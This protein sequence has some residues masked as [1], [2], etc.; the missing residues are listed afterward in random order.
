MRKRAER[1]TLAGMHNLETRL[2]REFGIRYPFVSAGM[3]FVAH[4]RLAAAVSNAGGLG[5]LGASPDP[6]ESLP[7]MIERLRGLTDGPFGVDL[8]CA[9]LPNG[10]ASTE[11]HIDRC[12][13]LGVKLVAFHHEL[14]PP[15][16]V[17]RLTAAGARV[18][19]QASSL[20]LARAAVALGMHGIVAQ[21]VEAGGHCESKVPVLDLV[22]S[23]RQAFPDLLILAAGGIVHGQQIVAALR[24][25]ADGG[26]LARG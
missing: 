15:W 18:W 21:G 19:Q 11:T 1:Q 10:P 17:E 24:A 26:G 2:T 22:G 7:V 12:V 3:G 20:E 25:G 6:P 4:E 14:P 13:E 5:F 16:W 23:I 9:T 8:I